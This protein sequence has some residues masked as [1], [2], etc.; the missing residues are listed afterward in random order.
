MRPRQ[1]IRRATF[2]GRSPADTAPVALAAA[3][4]IFDSS[5]VTNVDLTVVRIRGY[6]AV[7]TD[8]NVAGENVLGAV[9][10]AVVSEEAA[11]VGVGSLPTPYTDQDSGLWLSHRYWSQRFQHSSD[12][13]WS[14]Q[15]FSNFSFD[16]KAMRKMQ[17][18]TRL[19][20]VVENGAAAFGAVYNIFYSVLFK[21]GASR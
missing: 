2:W 12:T 8:Q 21:Q 5:F 1:S 19:V 14:N 6:I 16:S 13:G 7:S 20:I 15:G 17:P 11:S 9:G 18:S 4:S 3:T 10:F